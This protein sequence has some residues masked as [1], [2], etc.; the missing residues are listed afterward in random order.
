MR[1][2]IERKFP[3]ARL[4]DDNQE[5]EDNEEAGALLRSNWQAIYTK[6]AMLPKDIA[7][8]FAIKSSPEYDFLNAKPLTLDQV[9]SMWSAVPKYTDWAR[10]CIISSMACSRQAR[11]PAGGKHDFLIFRGLL[12]GTQCNRLYKVFAPKGVKGHDTT[13]GLVRPKGRT[14]IGLEEHR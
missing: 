13:E 2:A 7:K 12:T 10:W 1:T 14:S 11:S 3:L 5:T 4:T 8:Q 9:I 6:I